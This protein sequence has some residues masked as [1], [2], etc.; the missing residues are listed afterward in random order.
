MRD[1]DQRST[2]PGLTVQDRETEPETGVVGALLRLQGSAGNRAVSSLLVQ[3][4][5]VVAAPAPSPGMSAEDVRQL[6]YQA[7]VLRQVSPMSQEDQRSLGTL[8]SGFPVYENLLARDEK[9]RQLNE[10]NA[11][12]V[13]Y[14]RRNE[15]LARGEEL[16]GGTGA[17]PELMADLRSQAQA[18]T[19]EID[20]LNA[21]IW[22]ALHELGT[23]EAGLRHR[24]EEGFPAMWAARAHAIADTMLTENE[25]VVRREQTRYRSNVCSADVEGLLNAD[26]RLQARANQ[27]ADLRRQR[28][29]VDARLRPGGETLPGGVPEGLEEMTRD[30]TAIA[31]LDA[32][33]GELE[34]EQAGERSA[35]GLA[36]PILLSDS[37]R[38]GSIAGLPEGEREQ[39]IGSWTT[40]TLD[41]IARTRANIADGTLKLWDLRDVP[42]LTWRALGIPSSGPLGQVIERHRERE[43]S[44]EHAREVAV[45]ALAI[46]AGVVAGIATAGGAFVV[47]AAATGVSA[48][49][50][51]AQLGHDVQQYRAETAAGQ[52]SVDPALADI[53]R[54]QPQLLP[55]VMDIVGIGMDVGSAIGIARRVAQAERALTMAGDVERFAAEI[56]RVVPDAALAERVIARAQSDSAVVERVQAAV[57]ALGTGAR[58][59]ANLTLTQLM[60][61]I[62]AENNVFAEFAAKLMR[63]DRV[64]LMS[65]AAIRAKLTD[66]AKLAAALRD[67]ASVGAANGF[68]SPELRM[69][70]VAERNAQAMAGTLVHESVHFLQHANGQP[71][72]TFMAE[73]QAFMAQRDYLLSVARVAGN[74]DVVPAEY[75]WLVTMQPNEVARRVSQTYRASYPA[76]AAAYSIPAGF[77]PG[78]ARHDLALMVTCALDG[79]R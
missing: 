14:Q 50:G 28:Q 76:L 45:A 35:Q 48:G 67:L 25:N 27:I 53:S 11:A 71:L 44:E 62:G 21:R 19:Q 33:I 57:A 41:N 70:F 64:C 32:R 37:Y 61:E 73:Y 7:T 60:L 26:R 72:L 38:P 18:L 16:S 39:L 69:L 74:P 5:P 68:Y 3:R 54:N 59:Q 46:T 47:A 78:Q 2:R 51:L 43:R 77:T 63:E 13:D 49:I 56:R 12:Q 17:S 52:V 40:G 9:W 65:E 23:D 15:A 34:A 24:V 1:L 8:L 66:P 22:P 75:R 10:V 30:N 20:A 79:V 55:I 36:Y 6:A 58:T 29:E 31:T 4:D 42:E